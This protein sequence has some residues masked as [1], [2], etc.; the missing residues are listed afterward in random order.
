MKFGHRLYNTS[1]LAIAT[2]A[3]GAAIYIA[4]FRHSDPSVLT[5]ALFAIGLAWLAML[6][7]LWVSSLISQNAIRPL[8]VFAWRFAILLPALGAVTRM[9]GDERNCFL[10]VLLACY[11][12][13]LPLESWLLIREAHRLDS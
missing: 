7:P 11:F 2:A 13:G 8:A 1:L 6:P 5:I 12:V 10:S 9:Q 3:T 4:T